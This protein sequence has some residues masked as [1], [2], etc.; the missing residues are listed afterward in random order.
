MPRLLPST[1][2]GSSGQFTN[3]IRLLIKKVRNK[4][5][6]LYIISQKYAASSY[7]AR[8]QNIRICLYF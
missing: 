5:G 2:G 1:K 4:Y 3:E 6:P 7:K 8:P